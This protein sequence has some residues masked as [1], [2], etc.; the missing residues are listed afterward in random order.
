MT[1]VGYIYIYNILHIQRIQDFETPILFIPHER[2][3]GKTIYTHTHT[4][5]LNAYSFEITL[6]VLDFLLGKK[7]YNLHQKI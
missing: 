2:I 1:N 7:H 6:N 4:H 3:F 5:T